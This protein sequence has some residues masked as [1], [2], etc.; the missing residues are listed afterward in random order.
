M[1]TI[2]MQT[3]RYI[4]LFR[5]VANVNTKDCFL[6]NNAIIYVVPAKMMRQALG[7]NGKNVR[8]IQETLGKKIRVVREARD[9]RDVQRFIQDIVEPV[10]FKSLEIK[11]GN[12]ILTAGSL[13]KAALI[14]RN[15]RRL[16]ELSKIMEDYFGKELKIV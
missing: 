13:G 2:N 10:S 5:R 3:I 9:N 8:M 7:D 14:G 4:N 16:I 15:K 12:I 11:D 6:Y 1:T